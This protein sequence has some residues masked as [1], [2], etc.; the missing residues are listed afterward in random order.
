ME[1][2]IL[3]YTG[4][5]DYNVIGKLL[6]KV[7]WK[8]DEIG[9]DMLT[10]RKMYNI[11]GEC[12]ENISKHS[13]NE[14]NISKET[15]INYQNINID[16]IN[17]KFIIKTS[18][19]IH[20]SNISKFQNKLDKVNNSNREKLKEMFR[21]TIVNTEI[22]KKGG[23]SLGI[24]KIALISGKKIKYKFVPLENSIS[25]FNLEILLLNTQNAN[26]KI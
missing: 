7:Y 25:V 6:S 24:F 26:N 12:L 19:L 4:K 13:Y 23:A 21:D 22:S 1:K 10:K 5:I 9:I 11:M 8:M 18:N 14:N 20:N 16:L 15:I 17:D 3:Q 2:N